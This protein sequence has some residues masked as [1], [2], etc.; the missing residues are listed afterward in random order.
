MM[1]YDEKFSAADFTV[2]T[3]TAWMCK[4]NL[5]KIEKLKWT[6]LSRLTKLMKPDRCRLH[7]VPLVESNPVVKAGRH[8]PPW[9]LHSRLQ[10]KRR[11]E[12][13]VCYPTFNHSLCNS[14]MQT[15]YFPLSL[16]F[17]QTKMSMIAQHSSVSISSLPTCKYQPASPQQPFLTRVLSYETTPTLIS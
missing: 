13:V 2:K 15:N 5:K 16:C 1:K 7:L 11:W 10:A 17:T 14:W 8:Q 6:V 12:L 4:L 3:I 9:Q